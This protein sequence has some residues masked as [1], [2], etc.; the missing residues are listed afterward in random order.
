METYSA[1]EELALIRKM[2]ADT[3][4]LMVEDGKPSIVWGIIVAIGMTATYISALAQKDFGTGWMWIGLSI[5]GWVYIYYYR[6]QKVKTAKIRTLTGR[7]LGSIWGACGVCIGLVITLTYVAPQVS[8]EYLIHPLAITSIC[9]ILVG[10]AYYVSGIVYG[11]AWVRNI[12]FGWWIGAIVMLLWPSVH[13]LGM[14]AFM[15]IVF[16]VVPGIIVYRAS[17][18]QLAEASTPA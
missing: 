18:R 2:M 10:M 17:K 9:S 16:Q 5:L 15:L 12:S 13:V 14:Y 6:S 1:Q 4:T 8:G 7:I 11:K 3:R